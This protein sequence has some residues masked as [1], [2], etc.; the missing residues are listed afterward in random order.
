MG[1]YHVKELLPNRRS[2]FCPLRSIAAAHF[3]SVTAP[4]IPAFHMMNLT[5]SLYLVSDQ[6]P[7]K[8]G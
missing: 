5:V 2:S 4:I 7:S 1:R 3:Y 6:Y 8:E